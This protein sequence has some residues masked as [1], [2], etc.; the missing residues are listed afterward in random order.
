[1]ALTAFVARSF[2]PIDEERIRP[3]L[4]FLETFRKAGFLCDE[5]DAAEVERVSS[6]VRR[7]I[8]ERDAFVGFFTKKYPVYGLNSS[9]RNAVLLARG[10][11]EPIKW[12][13]PA[14]VLQESGYA[15]SARK[16]LILLR[17]E[18]VDL[19]GL[20]SD[21]E[22]VPFN[23]AN[24]SAIFSK[25]SE[26]INDLLAKD[27][28]REVRTQVTERA[29]EAGTATQQPPPMQEERPPVNVED[30]P[31]NIIAAYTQM[32]EAEEKHDVTAV[33]EAWKAGTALLRM[34]RP[35]STNYG[36]MLFTSSAGTTR[37]TQTASRN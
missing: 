7:M 37:G 33:R 17:E 12:T 19:P 20:Q 25:L 13:P 8:D 36:G 9:W 10:K 22:Y 32:R 35:S 4:N 26:M 15:L 29:E 16:R 21:L 6:K 27:A 14:W 28:G 11:L 3:I 2:D 34:V 5:A 1:M 31:L 30:Q 18:G 23:A 24:P